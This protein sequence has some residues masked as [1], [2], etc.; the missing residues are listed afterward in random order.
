MG[1]CQVNGEQR[2]REKLPALCCHL[3][4][5][6]FLNALLYKFLPLPFLP[7]NTCFILFNFLE[8]GPCFTPLLQNLLRFNLRNN[9]HVFLWCWRTFNVIMLEASSKDMTG[10]R[11]KG[12]EVSLVGMLLPHFIAPVHMNTHTHEI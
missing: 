2:E 8:N 10:Q 4:S 7:L 12:T 9:C 11:T 5:S 6:D 1:Q 3:P